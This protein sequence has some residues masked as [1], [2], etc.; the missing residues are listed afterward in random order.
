MFCITPPLH[1]SIRLPHQRKTSKA[2]SGYFSN[3]D[4]PPHSGI[5]VGP[6]FFIALFSYESER[7]APESQITWIWMFFTIS[8]TGTK[9]R[10]RARLLMIGRNC[11]KTINY[12]RA[13]I[14]LALLLLNRY[15]SEKP[16][17]PILFAAIHG[18]GFLRVLAGDGLG[19]AH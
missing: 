15:W 4:P 6:G 5:L 17:H 3:P 11:L 2:P 13:A 19:P 12:D 8:N 1:Y 10:V 7:V 9:V 16:G 14:C 18:P